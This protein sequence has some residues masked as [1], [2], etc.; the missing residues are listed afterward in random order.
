MLIFPVIFVPGG[1]HHFKHFFPLLIFA[2]VIVPNGERY[3]FKHFFPHLI[4]AV[5]IVQDGRALPFQ[6][7]LLNT[8]SFSLFVFSLV[9]VL[10]GR[11]VLFQTLDLTVD[12][13]GSCRSWRERITIFEMVKTRKEDLDT[14]P[15]WMIYKFELTNSVGL[16]TLFKDPNVAKHLS[17][18]CDKYAIVSPDNIVFVCKLHYIDCLIKELG[19]DN[20]LVNPT[21][22]PTTLTNPEQS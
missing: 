3:H 5:V 4:F 20:S 22:T 2:V 14:L 10:N 11:D 12:I 8:L 13:Y 7:L 17:L 1:R 21:Y 9:H 6:T 15:Q 19:I 16:W 18:L